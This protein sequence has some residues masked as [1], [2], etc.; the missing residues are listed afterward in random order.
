MST[1]Y[2]VRKSRCVLVLDSKTL[3]FFLSYVEPVLLL[4]LI[5]EKTNK[6][7]KNLKLSLLKPSFCTSDFYYSD[8]NPEV[9]PMKVLWTTCLLW[10]PNKVQKFRII[11]HHQKQTYQELVLSPERSLL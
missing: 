3:L 5:L 11:R 6:K 4:I 10:L 8:T 9:F 1:E 2:L 7:L